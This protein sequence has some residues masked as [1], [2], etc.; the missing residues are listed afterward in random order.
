MNNTDDISLEGFLEEHHVS[1]DEFIEANRVT[2]Q[3][4]INTRHN[5]NF[6]RASKIQRWIATGGDY[7]Y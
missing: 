5:I 7:A 1:I 4:L 2:V 3:N 6:N